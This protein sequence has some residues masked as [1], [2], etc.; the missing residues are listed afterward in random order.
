[1]RMRWCGVKFDCGIVFFLG[2][3][4]VNFGPILLCNLTAWS[5][6]CDQV[7]RALELQF[8]GPEFKFLS[9]R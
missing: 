4:G 2:G 7:V 6:Q 5:R 3:G 9:D 1:M 8:R